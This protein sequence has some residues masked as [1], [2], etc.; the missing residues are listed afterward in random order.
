[1]WK[2]ERHESHRDVYRE[3]E[4]QRDMRDRET[5]RL[6]RQE[7][8]GERERGREPDVIVTDCV[9]A[10]WKIGRDMIVTGVWR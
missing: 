1:M 6:V 4:R 10:V 3:T 5:E 9:K 2:T 7:Q 8:C